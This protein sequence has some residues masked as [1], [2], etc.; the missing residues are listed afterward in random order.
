MRAPL[1]AH[2]RDEC[3]TAASDLPLHKD[4]SS[5]TS[6]VVSREQEERIPL[7]EA[8][9][10]PASAEGGFL[11]DRAVRSADSCAT[12]HCI[13]ELS[14][15][16]TFDE[17]GTALLESAQH[18]VPR[19]AI[20]AEGRAADCGATAPGDSCTV[21][22]ELL[23]SGAAEPDG[24]TSLTMKHA[25]QHCRSSKT[26]CS[27]VRPC[28]RCTRLGLECVPFSEELRKRACTVCHRSK[29]SCKRGSAPGQCMRCES[30]GVECIARDPVA[31][32]GTKR[33]RR[34]AAEDLLS[35]ASGKAAGVADDVRA[36]TISMPQVLHWDLASAPLGTTLKFRSDDIDAQPHSGYAMFA[37]PSV[38]FSIPE[39]S[40]RTAVEAAVVQGR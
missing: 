29:V 38:A 40:L 21:G 3:M 9:L 27:E 17:C 22:R 4:D 2:T 20:S 36:L 33:R 26:A 30:L 28:I 18:G 24:S 6:T 35:L 7:A 39:G 16:S 34:G 5:A 12:A 1:P 10:A 23:T 19:M 15:S 37:P 32:R 31:L 25:C 8:R 13:L 11:E 14:R